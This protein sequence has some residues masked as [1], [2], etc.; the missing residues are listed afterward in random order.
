[1][2]ATPTRDGRVDVLACS[3][4]VLDL[5]SSVDRCLEL[6]DRNDGVV[7]QASVN[8]GKVVTCSQD[9]RMADFIRSCQLVNADGQAVVWAARLLGHPLPGRVAGVDLMDQ[10]LAEA[11]GRGL[12]VFILGAKQ[13]VLDE[14]MRR[15][16]KQHP[17]L[18]VAGARDGYFSEADETDVAREIAESR[19]D[20]LFVAMSSPKKEYFIEKYRGELG[21]RFAMGVGGAV[22]VLAGRI[23]RA[24]EWMQR[25][26]LEWLYR[27]LQEP[28]RMWRRY[29]VGNS[30]FTWL[31]FKALMKRALPILHK[32]PRQST[33][34]ADRGSQLALLTRHSIHALIAPLRR[35]P[36]T[37]DLDSALDAAVGYLCRTHDVTGRAG[38]SKGFHL[39]KGWMPAYPETTGYVI[40]TLLRCAEVREDEGYRLRAHQMGVWE[41]AVQNPDG[42][43]MEATVDSG[44][45]SIAFNTGMVLHGWLDLLEKGD[46]EG[47]RES[48][49]QAANF[50]ITNQDED[51]AWRGDATWRGLA[52]TYHSRVAWAL[53]RYGKSE[54]DPIAVAAAQMQFEWV[55]RQ[56]H[57]NGWFEN[58]TFAEGLLPNTHAIAYTIRGL[59]EGGLIDDEPRYVEAAVRTSEPLMRK[60]EE[61]G[62]LPATFDSSWSPGAR[63]VCLTGLVQLGD[64]WVKLARVTDDKRLHAAGAR[65]I[66]QVVG[67]Q[68]RSGGPAH[69]AL[70]GSHPI[71]GR[72][73]PFQ[74]PNWAT[75][76][77]ADA[78]LTLRGDA[79]AA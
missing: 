16:R 39:L 71:Y 77:L 40:G 14:A 33:S 4:D 19:A 23:T 13:A 65:A 11:A 32:P 59:L 2:R 15:L 18:L 8:A 47:F 76:F 69:G 17:Q 46:D 21:V 7:V 28:R 1:M 12:S 43:V 48:A 55:L 42:G 10:I 63:Y 53:L 45:G 50:L 30:R 35:E 54:D 37:R 26:G 66:E 36:S 73:S 5:R 62:M 24:P 64:V 61:L 9:A 67:K 57:D 75:K 44:K 49:R 20:I 29:L 51:G 34:I 27:F 58:C 60:S 79:G 78:L 31:L 56:Q 74:Y 72:Y 52:T 70:A 38:S 41:S 22:D 6:I 25:L 3:I 68:E